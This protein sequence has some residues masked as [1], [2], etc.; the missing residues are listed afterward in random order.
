M[1]YVVIGA[2]AVGMLMACLLKDAG[3]DVDILARRKD[4]ADLINEQGIKNGRAFYMVDARTDL[5]GISPEAILLLAVKYDAL[6]QLLPSLNEKCPHNPIVFLQNGMMHLTYMEEMSQQ[7]LLAGS[8]EHGVIKIGDNEILHTGNGTVKFALLKGE[9]RYFSP[10][11]QLKH[12]KSEWHGDADRMLFRKVLLN[13][14]INPLTALMGIKN[15]E[16]LTNPFAYEVL[17]DVYTELYRAFPE[18]DQ[19]LPFEEVTALCASTAENTSSMLSDRLQGRKMELD[20][21][22]LYTIQRAD[23]ELPLLKGLYHIL[24]SSEV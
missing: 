4:Q 14:I 15:G 6:E 3:A 9:E 24:K 20:T 1:E 7:H 13:S 8:V 21:I 5:A 16:L 10:L 12:L 2:G 19:L 22:L 11:Q 17:K 23:V 18:I